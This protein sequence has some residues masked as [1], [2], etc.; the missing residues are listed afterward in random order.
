MIL[1]LFLQVPTRVQAV[2]TNQFQDEPREDNHSIE[3]FQLRVLNAK[4]ELDQLAADWVEFK[5]EN[6]F[7][8]A[9]LTGSDD[10]ILEVFVKITR[11]LFLDYDLNLERKT[12]I[13]QICS[14]IDT[15]KLKYSINQSVGLKFLPSLTNC[16]LRCKTVERYYLNLD[17]IWL[18]LRSYFAEN[19]NAIETRCKTFVNLWNYSD[20]SKKKLKIKL[21]IT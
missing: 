14:H 19:I 11:F 8:T 20:Q 2:V 15:I 13:I 3:F 21:N 4:L 16:L 17:I 7:D 18:S 12:K 10:Y 1:F 5:R 9:L 6:V